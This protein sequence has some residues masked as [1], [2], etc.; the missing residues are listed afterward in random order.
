MV[1][2]AT[3]AITATC[4]LKSERVAV[5]RAIGRLNDHEWKQMF[6]S[7][8]E[9]EPRMMGCDPPAFARL[10]DSVM[11]GKDLRFELIGQAGRAGARPVSTYS[12]R[13]FDSNGG[14]L[15]NT[16]SLYV[17]KS[18][19][20]YCVSIGDI[21]F[22][23]A[24]LQSEDWARS[25]RDLADAMERES[26]TRLLNPN[27]MIVTTPAMIREAVSQD[28]ELEPASAWRRISGF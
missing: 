23:C 12:L 25:L 15:P 28:G 24:L 13:V 21:P 4:Y 10:M 20:R 5:Q 7:A 22:Q 11:E 3:G 2:L 9:D 18:G 14:E 16:L 8:I 27:D 26:V 6:E 1:V 17:G 19:S